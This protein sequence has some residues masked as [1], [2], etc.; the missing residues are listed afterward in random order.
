MNKAKVIRHGDLCL[1]YEENGEAIKL[2]E[3]LKKSDSKVLL[4]GSGG[5]SH[6]YDNGEFYPTPEK[7]FVIGYFVAFS[8][9][10]FFHL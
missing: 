9:T 10:K 2:P 7:D 5:N 8:N 3:G 4:I 1:V 6:T